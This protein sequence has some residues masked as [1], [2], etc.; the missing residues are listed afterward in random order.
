MVSTIQQ[1]ITGVVNSIHQGSEQVEHGLQLANRAGNALHE[2]VDHVG[3]INERVASMAAAN[4]EQAG[5]SN[6]I[7]QST[8]EIASLTERS[9]RE[10]HEI[11]AASEVL[12]E[13]SSNLSQLV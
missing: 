3:A 2:I 13:L 12:H 11:S 9:V 10:A 8:D 6:L 5:T 1:E 4:E 7:A